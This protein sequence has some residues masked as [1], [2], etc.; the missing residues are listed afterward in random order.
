MVMKDGPLTCGERAISWSNWFAA[1]YTIR[2]DEC[3]EFHRALLVDPLWDVP[4]TKAV[5]VTIT[6]FLM[7]PLEHVSLGLKRFML[8]L[9]TDVPITLIFLIVIVISGYRVNFFHLA[10]IAPTPTESTQ[11]QALEDIRNELESLRFEVKR[12]QQN[13]NIIKMEGFE[14]D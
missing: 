6:R 14:P 13:P 4:P 7:E 8:G 9:V 1:L 3:F 2:S 5:A 12:A 10:S 11:L